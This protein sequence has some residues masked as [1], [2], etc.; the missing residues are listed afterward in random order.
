MSY[1][2]KQRM[3]YVV[4]LLCVALA[5]MCCHIPKTTDIE[6]IILDQ[7]RT[8]L[9]LGLYTAWG[10]YLQK[11]VVN[12]KIRRCLVEIACLMVFWIFLR[13]IKYHIMTE[14]LS[15]RTCWYLYYIPCM[16]IPTLGLNAAILMGEEEEKNTKKRTAALVIPA[17]LFVVAVLTNDFHQLVFSFPNGKPFID[18]NYQYGPIFFGIQIWAIFCLIAME[19]ILIRKSKSPQKRR[20][21]LPFFPGIMLLYWNFG[22]VIGTP[23][24]T[25]YFG[26][27]AV[28]CCLLMSAIY[29]SCIYCGL[30]GTNTRYTELFQAGGGI[31]AEIT[32]GDWNVRYRSGDFPKMTD[33]MRKDTKQGTTVTGTWNPDKAHFFARRS[34]ILGRRCF[35]S[36]GSV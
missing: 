7:S 21:W 23:L 1:S 3:A 35:T 4:V 14:I 31:T 18:Q 2:K 33:Q 5:A 26:D 24:I 20:F 28:S 22:N 34:C 10:I 17:I 36:I 16:M 27:M 15:L 30:I 11:R 6:S 12:P 19:V 29:Q 13:S 32:D 9:Y 8:C 25:K